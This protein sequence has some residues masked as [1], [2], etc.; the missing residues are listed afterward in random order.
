MLHTLRVLCWR[1]LAVFALALAAI[2]IPLPGLPTVPFVLVAAWAGSRGWPSL[3]AT[4]VQHP[5]Y[6]PSI[7]A[8]RHRRAVPR[9]AKYIAIL[10]MVVS[11][12]MLFASNA[13]AM[14]KIAL[15]LFLICVA[16]WLW[17]RPE[18]TQ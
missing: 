18:P 17:R 10:M 2:G 14:L 9:K 8:W 15:P 6:G 16:M 3:E 1:A 7:L 4:L 12:L 13:P 5:T 11:A